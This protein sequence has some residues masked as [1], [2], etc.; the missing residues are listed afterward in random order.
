MSDRVL[1]VLEV[2]KTSYDIFLEKLNDPQPLMKLR[3]VSD[4]EKRYKDA[5]V[6][7]GKLF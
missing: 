3:S 5:A 4:C 7:D 1:P 6:I 2:Q